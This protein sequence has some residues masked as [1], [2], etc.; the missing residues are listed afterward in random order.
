MALLMF[1]FDKWHFKV[2]KQMMLW[3]ALCFLLGNFMVGDSRVNELC[4]EDR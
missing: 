1:S 4:N 2:D 3:H